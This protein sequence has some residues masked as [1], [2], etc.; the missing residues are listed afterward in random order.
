MTNNKIDIYD[1]FLEGELVNL[2]VLNE[3]VVENS[4][5]YKWLNSEEST[6]N[7]QKHYFPNTKL[8]QMNFLKDEIE[9][10]NTK[11][12]LGIFQKDLSMLTGVIS[13]SDINYI[14]STAE[15]AV[16]IGEKS[17]RKLKYFN[18]SVRLIL[19]HA[20]YTLNLNRVY[21]GS[22]IKEIDLLFCR[23]LGFTHEGISKQAVYKNGEYLDV[24]HHALLKKDF[25]KES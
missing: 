18:E 17:G 9:G 5:W 22:F 8:I 24:Y 20:F 16:F 2:V 23:T 25:K 15:V 11:L 21:S 7:M 3:A 4:N 10:S 19:K 1:I 12:Q 6:E 14:N 13:L